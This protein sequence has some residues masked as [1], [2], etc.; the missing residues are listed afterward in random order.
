MRVHPYLSFKG[1]CEEA[2]RFYEKA[3]GGKLQEFYR[4]EGSPM[5][6][7]APADWGNKI[8]HVSMTVD[9]DVL[10]GADAPPQYFTKTEGMTVT[11]ALDDPAKGE[12]IFNALAE[13][14][15]VKMKFEP[16]FWAKGFGMC[17]DRFGIPWMVNCG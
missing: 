2:F 6:K 1:Q 7:D 5:M 15:I 12:R 17:I 3:L 4:Y 11:L 13:G 10:A 9:N 14:G 16:T 8:M